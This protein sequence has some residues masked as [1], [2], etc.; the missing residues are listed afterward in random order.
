M[1]SLTLSSSRVSGSS[2]R[3][4]GSKGPPV[5]E[6]YYQVLVHVD[7]NLPTQW[8]PRLT[9]VQAVEALDAWGLA[10]G[11]VGLSAAHEDDLDGQGGNDGLGVHQ[12]GVAQVVQAARAEDLGA[13]LEPG[14]LTELDASVLLQQLGRHA[15]QSAQ[16]GP[17]GM[18]DLDRAVAVS[19]DRSRG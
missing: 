5:V 18:D 4:R 1:I 19:K 16:H 13:S 17:A 3:F 2:P 6:A 12:G 10:V 9:W 7:N 15:A 11:A 14:G 8:K